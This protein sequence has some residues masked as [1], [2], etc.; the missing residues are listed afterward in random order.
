M[1]STTSSLEFKDLK[2]PAVAWV[3][4]GG[5]GYLKPAPGT[6]GSLVALMV[7][8]FL[9]G[10][11]PFVYQ[12]LVVTGYLLVSWASCEYVCRHYDI[13]DAQEIV[14]DEVAGMW[15]V[16]IWLPQIWWLAL[17]GFALFRLLDITKP[18]AIGWLDR[19]IK[20]GT[21]VMLDDVV[22]GLVAGGVLKLALFFYGMI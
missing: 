14:A 13:E 8:W 22:V 15:L 9:L 3:T 6:W 5:V 18:L 12:G 10:D 17:I 4:A 1:A 7:W 19:E 21:G 20:G 2:N 11:L 16:L